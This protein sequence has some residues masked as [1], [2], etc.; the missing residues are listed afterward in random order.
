MPK[1]SHKKSWYMY[2]PISNNNTNS[3]VQIIF[4][5]LKSQKLLNIT[6]GWTK[7]NVNKSLHILN[8]Y[9]TGKRKNI[10]IKKKCKDQPFYMI[11]NYKKLIKILIK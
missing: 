9:I 2:K 6:E 10:D 1:D 3:V 8:N 5:S 11:Y 4:F 7:I